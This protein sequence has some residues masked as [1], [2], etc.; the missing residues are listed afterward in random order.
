MKFSQKL[1]QSLNEIITGR[2]A[3]CSAILDA[4]AITAARLIFHAP[5]Q[6]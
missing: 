1:N 4:E 6:Y 3:G 2:A 5:T